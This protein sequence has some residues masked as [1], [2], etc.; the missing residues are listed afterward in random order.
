MDLYTEIDYI[1]HSS[2]QTKECENNKIIGYDCTFT[3][4]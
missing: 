1:K 2:I 3:Y 4:E